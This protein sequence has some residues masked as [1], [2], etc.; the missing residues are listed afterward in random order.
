MPA[1][2]ALAALLLAAAPA[3]A[4]AAQCFDVAVVA[5]VTGTASTEY[6]DDDPEVIVMYWP[7]F[8]DLEVE[9]LLIGKERRERLR[10]TAMLH[11][12]YNPDIRHFLF[13]LRR[14]EDGRYRVVG[15]DTYIAEDHK[16][17]FVRPLAR[18]PEDHELYPARPMPRGY[19]RWLKPLRYDV[20]K[21]WWLTP[22]FADSQDL[23]WARRSRGRAFAPRGLK[24]E[25]WASAM[26]DEPGAV[27]G[28]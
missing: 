23:P 15:T 3:G 20:R 21:A 25:D 16:G 14:G 5:R 8:V 2:A 28:E 27:C 19:A 24:V 18:P 6:P 13:L 9:Q 11:A 17:R 7:W 1:G 12:N 22:Q 10:V 4:E 26:A